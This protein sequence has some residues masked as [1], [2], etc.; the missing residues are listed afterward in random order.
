M[1]NFTAFISRQRIY[2]DMMDPL[3]VMHNSR[4]LLLFERARFDLWHANGLSLGAE[5][6]DWPY[7]VVRNEINYHA[8]ITRLQEVTVEVVVE[9]LGSSSVTLAHRVLDDTNVCVADGKTVLVR[10]DPVTQHS[11]AWSDGFRA[12]LSKYQVA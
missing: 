9:R 4:Y 8:P 2:F 3:G 1:E 7:Y 5:G 11:A 12:L 6:L 10:V